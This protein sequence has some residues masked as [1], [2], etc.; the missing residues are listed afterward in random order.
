MPATW[1]Q[2]GVDANGDGRKYP[3]NPVDAIFA[4][5]SYLRAAGAED[6]L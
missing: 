1:K 6:D 2:Y 3:F 4:A 5:A